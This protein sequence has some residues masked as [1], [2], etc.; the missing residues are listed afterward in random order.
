MGRGLGRELSEVLSWAGPESSWEEYQGLGRAWGLVQGANDAG[1]R[2]R[3][4]Y[5]SVR[6]SWSEL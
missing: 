6:L 2:R 3:P 1:R 4:H 5:L